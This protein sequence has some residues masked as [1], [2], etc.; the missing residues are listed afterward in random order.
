MLQVYCTFL[1]NKSFEIFLSW[2]ALIGKLI[3]NP[4]IDF[5]REINALARVVA[6]QKSG[7]GE[8]KFPPFL[9][10]LIQNSFFSKKPLI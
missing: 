9:K 4:A 10:E 1:Y 6:S 5:V 8:F 7:R 3:F 2:M